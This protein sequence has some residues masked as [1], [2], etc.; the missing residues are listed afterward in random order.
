MPASVASSRKYAST[1]GS[2]R[3]VTAV[4][5]RR[6]YFGSARRSLLKSY[7]FLMTCFL[8]RACAPDRRAREAAALSVES[9]SAGY[10]AGLPQ[11]FHDVERVVVAQI[12]VGQ[13]L[14]ARGGGHLVVEK[15]RR[16]WRGELAEP[17]QLPVAE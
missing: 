1:T 14:A 2:S 12:R 13:V 6:R 17:G 4:L 10:R 9:T 8:Q 15:R 5:A 7:S 16:L 3:I 11:P